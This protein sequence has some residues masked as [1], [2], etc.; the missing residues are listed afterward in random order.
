M[1]SVLIAVPFLLVALTLLATAVHTAEY[2]WFTLG[3]G[4][5]ALVVGGYAAWIAWFA[6]PPPSPPAPTPDAG[7]RL[8]TIHGFEAT[9]RTPLVAQDEDTPEQM[10]TKL[11]CGVCHQIP[12][13]VAAQSGVEGPLLLPKV[14]AERRMASPT[15]RAA[16]RSGR[17]GAQTPEDYVRESILRPNAFIV[18]GFEQRA[19]PDESAMPDHFGA[20]FTVA[21]LDKLIEYLLSVDCADAARDNL[22]GPRVESVDR[23]CGG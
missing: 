12:G 10:I 6:P 17:A 8:M 16:V 22:K 14:T 5:S 20:T 1:T 7:E 11:G 23:L 19:R 21:G 2:R 3:V 13:I 18:P 15:Y 4:A 9:P